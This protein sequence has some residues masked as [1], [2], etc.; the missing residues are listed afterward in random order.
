MIPYGV[1][2]AS[3]SGTQALLS[4]PSLVWSQHR[5]GKKQAH[6]RKRQTWKCSTE[7]SIKKEPDA[8]TFWGIYAQ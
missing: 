4:F 5:I 6:L 3:F 7:T 8:L 2:P 1:P